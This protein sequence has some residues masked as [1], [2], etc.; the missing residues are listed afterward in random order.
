MKVKTEFNRM[1]NVGIIGES[2]DNVNISCPPKTTVGI[3]FRHSANITLA[4]LTVY[5]CSKPQNSSSLNFTA[6]APFS[7]MEYTV[8]IY[9]L[10]CMNVRVENVIISNSNGTGMTMFNVGGIVSLR[11]SSF[12]HNNCRPGGSGLQISFTYCVPGFLN[13][14][15]SYES[16]IDSKHSSNAH[17]TIS[18]CSFI[19]NIG[20]R[21]YSG[22]RKLSNV[23]KDTFSF[24]HGGG[25]SVIF[26]GNASRN[27]F[28]IDNCNISKNT[29]HM[30][31]GMYV[32]YHDNTTDNT[33]VISNTVFTRNEVIEKNLHAF[34]VDGGGGGMKVIFDS[35]GSN[36]QSLLFF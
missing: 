23:G 2:S 20:Y 16:Q 35:R 28:T 13:C 4:N 17:Y 34:D 32:S 12:I 26:K 33:V 27:M 25:L 30:G 3:S 11:G 18:N 10:L 14:S 5:G 19:R 9:I 7:Y 31:A 6:G 21:G 24:G 29:A 36:T 15:H 8:S 22:L 1:F